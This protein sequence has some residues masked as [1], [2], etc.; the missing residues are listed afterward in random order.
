MLGVKETTQS[1]VH[2]LGS[3]FIEMQNIKPIQTY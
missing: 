2:V 1:V 3:I